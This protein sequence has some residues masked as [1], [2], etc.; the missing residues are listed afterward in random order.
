MSDGPNAE[1]AEF[2]THGSGMKW[3]ER[4]E[5]LNATFEPVNELIAAGAQPLAGAQVLDIGCGTGATARRMAQEAA[6]VH[7]TDISES[8]LAQARRSAQ[9]V[10]NM[11][12]ALAD[13]QTADLGEGVYDIAVS[14]F[15]VMFF[16]DPVA[17]FVNIRRALKPGGRLAMACWA[18]FKDNPWFTIPRFIATDRLG[19]LPPF[20]P[21]APGPFAFAETDRTLGILHDAGFTARVSTQTLALTPRGGA[22]QVAD[23][24]TRVGP[25]QTVLRE[26]NG[27]E[28]DLEAIRTEVEAA[29]KPFETDS[30][31]RVPASIHLYTAQA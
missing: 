14:R 2:W 12:F 22:A 13:A 16:A 8:L 6:A 18:P 28:E 26:R 27:T 21:Y 23:L 4:E 19:R 3:V 7:A 24:A 1:Q 30:G 17:A 10:P 20:D 9:G 5:D 31:M 11:T 29:F 15:G 25:A